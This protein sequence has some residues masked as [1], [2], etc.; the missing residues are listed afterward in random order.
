MFHVHCTKR[1]WCVTAGLLETREPKS[2]TVE[3]RRSGRWDIIGLGWD[4]WELKVEIEEDAV[5]Y[6]CEV[7]K[8]ELGG[9]CSEPL[10]ECD[11][12]VMEIGALEDVKVPLMLL[13][14]SWRVVNMAGNGGL[15]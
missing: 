9:L 11:L 15:T 5:V 3:I 10:E 14:V 1:F 6:C 12:V 2:V 13:C 4:E 7:L 8:F